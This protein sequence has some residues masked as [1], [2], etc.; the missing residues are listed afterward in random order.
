MDAK[1]LLA[2][3]GLSD[4]EMTMATATLGLSID[5]IIALIMQYGPAVVAIIKAIIQAISN[6]PA[7]TG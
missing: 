3:A 4:D 2:D 1:K 5:Q 7:P 6:P